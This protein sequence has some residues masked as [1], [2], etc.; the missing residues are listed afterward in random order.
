MDMPPLLPGGFPPL[1]KALTAAFRRCSSSNAVFLLRR[2]KKNKPAAIEETA[3]TPTTTP[4]AM[5]TLFDFGSLCAV[6]EGVAD[7]VV[8]GSAV[9]R[10]RQPMSV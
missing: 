2:T 6:G 1:M 10:W 5:P 4:T 3:K 8:V 9:S 7:G